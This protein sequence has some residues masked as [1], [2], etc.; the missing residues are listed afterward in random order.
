MF[1][2]TTRR[3]PRP[4]TIIAIVAVLLAGAGSATAASIITGK[5]VKDGTL[6]GRDVKNRS[7]SSS[8]L[9]K[10]AIAALKGRKGATGP[11]G[12]AGPAGAKGDKGDKGDIGPSLTAT[13]S[14][15][16][17]SVADAQ[18]IKGFTLAA[19]DYLATA[20]LVATGGLDASNAKCGLY[21]EIGTD[22]LLEAIDEVALHL[23]IGESKEMVMH[24]A[25]S[26]PESRNYRLHCDPADKGVTLDDV[27]LT[28]TK[29]GAITPLT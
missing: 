16:S 27:Q 18:K 8:D 29:V 12:A 11:A 22:P 1:D 26:T 9:S 17:H 3:L 10:K 15:A 5:Q 7:L 14:K 4:A 20:K 24:A 19:G 13:F 25:I 2:N 6:T 28:V 23:D 21:R